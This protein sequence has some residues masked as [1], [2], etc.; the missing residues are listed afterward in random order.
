M[1]TFWSRALTIAAASAILT[2]AGGLAKFT[3]VE[4]DLGTR[5]GETLTTDGQPWAGVSFAG[6]EATVRGTAPTPEERD[7]ALRAVEG[8]WGVRSVRDETALL[9][10]ASPYR[11]LIEKA[12]NGLQLSGVVPR[13]AARTAFTDK[14]K[15]MVG[16]SSVKDGLTL[17]RGAPEGFAVAYDNGLK[18]LAVLAGGTYEIVDSTLSVSGE[19]A[20]SEAY[21]K[22]MALVADGAPSGFSFGKVDILAPEVTPF[23]WSATRTAEGIVL[24]GYV[25]DDETRKALVAAAE[26]LG[27]GPVTDDMKA[28]RGAAD[29]FS[30]LATYGVSRLALLDVG[31]TASLSGNALTLSGEAT[32]QDAFAALLAG[33]GAADLSA[34]AITSSV[35]QPAISPY[36]WSATVDGSKVTLDGYVPDE[37]TR[38]KVLALSGTKFGGFTIDDKMAIGPGAPGGFLP[39]ITT[40]LQGVSRLDGGTVSLS[41]QSITLKGSTFYA[42]ALEAVKAYLAGHLPAGFGADTAGLAV[43]APG[44]PVSSSECQALLS[45][46]LQSRRILFETGKA[47]IREDSFGLLD[48]LVYLTQRCPDARVEIEGHT[49]SDGA[50]DANQVLSEA[51]AGAVVAYLRNAGVAADRLTAIGY[52]ETRPVASNDSE[53]GKAQNRRIEFRVIGE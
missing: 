30:P 48:N 14:A 27:L 8:V 20:D 23:T 52:G 11:L 7:A 25:P 47:A 6:R 32:S 44:A 15:A 45:G 19:A 34:A 12:G 53:E 51:R 4:E 26:G 24:S 49:D 22:A 10:I 38:K 17:G 41:D 42:G 37:D 33:A 16:I 50:D 36:V 1:G 5:S 2:A 29:G 39:A 43:G 40:A 28:A 18:I 31:G 3:P 13:E 46:M 9:P 21:D 35:P